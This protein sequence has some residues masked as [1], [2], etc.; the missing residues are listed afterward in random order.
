MQF[1]QKKDKKQMTAD[2]LT[3][4]KHFMIHQANKTQTLLENTAKKFSK[5]DM[6]KRAELERNHEQAI[7]LISEKQA[8]KDAQWMEERVNIT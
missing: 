1:E 2:L 7:K 4:K 8:A 5:V 6:E 3:Q